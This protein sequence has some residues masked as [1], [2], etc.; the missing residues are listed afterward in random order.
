MSLMMRTTRSV[1][2]VSLLG[3]I[4]L[5]ALASLAHAEIGYKVSAKDFQSRI[6]IEM[7]FEA[8]AGDVAVSMP[9]WAPGSYRLVDVF[10]RVEDVTFTGPDGALTFSKQTD[11]TWRAGLPKAGTVTVSYTMPSQPTGDVLHYAGP[12]TYMYVVGRKEEA[13]KLTLDVPSGWKIAVGLDLAGK[14]PNEFKAKDYDVLADNPVTVGNFIELN[15]TS[16]GKPH[17]I[18]MRG[19]PA[20]EVDP[21]EL[22]KMCKFVSD[23]QGDFF[24][25]LPFNKYVWHFNV[26]NGAGGGGLEH[27]TSTQITFSARQLGN[28]TMRLFAHEFFHLWNVKRIRSRVLGP[29]DYDQLPQTGALWWLEGT[30]D[31]YAGLLPLRYGW[32]EP[33]DFFSDALSNVRAVRGN[34]A[35]L[36][37]SPHDAS[38]RVR[39]A[40][41]G[42]GNSNG[43]NI[44]YYNLGW[45]L[46]LCLDIEMRSRTQGRRSLDDVMKALW[47]MCKNDKPGF[48][49][50]E[51]RKQ[52]VRFGG[53]ALGDCY[54]NWVMKAGELPIEEQ[55]GK[56]G[57]MLDS[58]PETYVDPGFTVGGFGGGGGGRNNQGQNASPPQGARISGIRDLSSPLSNGDLLIEVNGA[59]VVGASFQETNAKAR[60]AVQGLKAGEAAKLK[61]V[62]D[63]KTLDVEVTP[64]SAQR[65]SFRIRDTEAPTKE[66]L[67]LR[68]GWYYAGK[69]KQ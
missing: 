27:L 13:C 48:E 10:A 22:I 15:Y 58:S 3:A 65:P 34:S 56:M 57:L 47:E 32:M 37:V 67:A 30:T 25:G 49:E 59:S 33:E 39:E 45:L 11:N 8:K 6:R 66:Q 38:F 68:Q 4:A 51:I 31:Y 54:D 14:T 29:F 20:A 24:G 52:L 23:S 60:A 46:G 63:D 12:S 7:K 50:G 55:L 62:R 21:D 64:R 35:R 19:A 16:H 41:N 61:V 26:T 42:R 9:N 69:K 53:P 2:P 5:L 44:S 18:A 43:Y 36:E 17:Q 28:G 1:R 40:A